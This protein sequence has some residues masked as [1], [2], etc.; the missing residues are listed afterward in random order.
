MLDGT[1]QIIL[2]PTGMTSQRVSA[3]QQLAMDGGGAGPSGFSSI[4]GGNDLGAHGL[5][6]GGGGVGGAGVGGNGS[7]LVGGLSG[8]GNGAGS[9]GGHSS[10]SFDMKV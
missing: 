5:G 10:L 8:G 7:G 6:G 2:G 3:G 4:G 1:I 9:P